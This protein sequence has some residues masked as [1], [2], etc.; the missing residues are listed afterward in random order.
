M[1]ISWSICATVH[2]IRR[3]RHDA[4]SGRYLR[5]EH[6]ADLDALRSALDHERD[7]EQDEDG[8]GEFLG[9]FGDPVAEACAESVSE[10]PVVGRF[11]KPKTPAATPQDKELVP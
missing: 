5:A 8:A 11:M 7:A 6:D 1:L 3:V 2:R 9:A 4:L 10:L